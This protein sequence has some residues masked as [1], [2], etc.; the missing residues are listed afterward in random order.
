MPD[1]RSY[2][3]GIDLLKVDGNPLAIF[4]SNGYPPTSP[5][6]NW[7]HDVYSASLNPESPGDFD[8]E[9]LYG[10]D[11]AQEPSSS[12]I[13]S[14]G[15]IFVTSEDGAKG[16]HQYGA[17]FNSDLTTKVEYGDIF[18]REGGH[19]GHTTAHGNKF[20]TTYSEGWVDG[21]G[22][23][24]LGSGRDVWVRFV[25]DNGDMGN[26]IL[27]AEG[28]NWWPVIASSGDETLTVWQK[29]EDNGLPSLHAAIV[30]EDGVQSTQEIIGATEHY[31]YD[32]QF[33]PEL[34]QYLILGTG[35]D[36]NGY[37]SLVN[38]DGD[39][40]LTE[41]GL[42][43]A[44][45]REAQFTVE[46]NTAVY[47]TDGGLA[48]LNVT[49]NSI[50]TTEKVDGSI[51]WDGIG[52]DGIFVD[53]DTV[54][55]AGNTTDGLQVMTEDV[56]V[57]DSPVTPEEPVEEPEEP[58]EP[59]G[60][61]DPV[62]PEEPVDPVEEPTDPEE[63]VEEPTDPEEPVDPVEEPVEPEVPT[64]NEGPGRGHGHGRWK[65][66]GKGRDKDK[67]HPGN[68]DDD[69]D[70][71]EG[72]TDDGEPGRGHG[73]G[74]GRDKDRPEDR[75]DE[76]PTDPV[77]EPEEPVEEPTDPVEE[78]EEPVDEPEE[79]VED[80]EE[81]T[82][83]EPEEP[84]EEPTDP[85]SEGFG[86]FEQEIVDL[87]NEYRAENGVPAL[88]INEKL[89]FASEAHSEDMRDRGFFE[90][91]NP[92]GE[93]AGDRIAET[94]LD[95]QGWGENIAVGYDTPEEAMEGWMTSPGHNSNMLRAEW[96][97][98]GVGHVPGD[99]G[100]DWDNYWTQNFADLV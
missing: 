2:M 63:P 61:V 19:S 20:A 71:G 53:G 87:V 8:I 77:D 51:D 44:T 80:P 18:V 96:D 57:G 22:V 88:T 66:K 74:K 30:T 81:P 75:D 56:T 38:K 31:N 100:S 43:N 4:A 92:D 7:N 84:V 29:F 62:D 93:R 40:T 27:V 60:P 24:D 46:G 72:P 48:V 95:N 64:D 9:T 58:E 12:A 82:D 99:D 65:E 86:A 79:P 13:N 49:E 21:G 26:E 16:I 34:N 59:T 11:E 35:E 52:S 32:V 41:T 98:I 25:D 47:P 14:E 69:E 55:F 3:H 90:H 78:P 76:D 67:D 94:G 50:S 28:R 23:D 6:G 70:D 17:L 83:P 45:I 39:V 33:V 97:A 37:A 85:V 10:G 73:K 5:G 68:R 89:N 36:G 42:E 1:N 15:T 54:L 91:M